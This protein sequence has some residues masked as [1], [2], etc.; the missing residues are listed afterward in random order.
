MSMFFSIANILVKNTHSYLQIKLCN[1][2]ASFQI[3]LWNNTPKHI[4]NNSQINEAE[5]NLKCIGNEQL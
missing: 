4:R 1:N 3:K 2:T 5:S